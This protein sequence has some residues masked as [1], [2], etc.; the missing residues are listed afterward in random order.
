MRTGRK[1]R[2]KMRLEDGRNERMDDEE[3]EHHDPKISMQFLH[4]NADS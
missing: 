4:G 3:Q 1:Q 2:I